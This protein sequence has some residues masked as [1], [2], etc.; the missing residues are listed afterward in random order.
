MDK[1]TIKEN[2]RI[3]EITAKG[4]DG[5]TYTA[6][7]GNMTYND[8]K[9]YQEYAQLA[10]TEE[11]IL[12]Y[13]AKLTFIDGDKILLE[14]ED[15]YDIFNSY[16]YQLRDVLNAVYSTTIKRGLLT[17][18]YVYDV[19]TI[20]YPDIEAFNVE[21]NDEAKTATF[22]YVYKEVEGEDTPE[23][24]VIKDVKYYMAT[25]KYPTRSI[26]KDYMKIYMAGGSVSAGLRLAENTFVEGDT[27]LKSKKTPNIFYAALANFTSVIEFELADVKK[28]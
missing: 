3:I 12:V 21:L 19:D 4:R 9:K 23:P 20:K 5:K 13:L 1:A 26:W 24:F 14:D 8:Y 22:T 15:R 11:D 18:I 6:R 17:D 25:F 10:K 16:K 27:E 7:F 28:K 2:N